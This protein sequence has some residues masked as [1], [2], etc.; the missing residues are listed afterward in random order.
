M[1]QVDHTF[2]L[3]NYLANLTYDDLPPQVIDQAKKSILNSLG[4]GIGYCLHGP[5]EKAFSIIQ[6]DGNGTTATLLGRRQRASIDNAV[7]INGI[8]LTTA[9]YDDTHLK[10]VIHPAGTSLAA[11]L[12]WGEAY[13]MSN[14]DFILAFV[15][16][17]ETQCAVG[18]AISPSHYAQGW[19]VTGTTGSF[20]AAAAISKARKL[21][22]YQFAA[23]LGHSASMASGI[24][25]MFGVDT[26][27]LHMG[28]GAQNGI[29]AARLAAGGFQSC[30]SAIEA[31]AQLV[32]T[33]IHVESISS[34]VET[35]TYEML[36]NTFKP[37]PCG[38][39]IHPLID[40]AVEAHST[41]RWGSVQDQ[42]HSTITVRDIESIEATVNPQC[43][44]LCSVRH[45]KTGLET[46]FSLYH[47]IAVGLL[48]GCAGPDQFSDEGCN[49]PLVNELRDQIKVQTSSDLADDAAILMVKLIGKEEQVFHVEHATGSL[50]RP[51]DIE[52]LERKFIALSSGILG[53]QRATEIMEE[54]WNLERVADMAD[55]VGKLAPS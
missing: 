4:C 10:T 35:G 9:D 12:S 48:Y 14:R 39:V 51:M 3:A 20:G 33:T 18:N 16:G 8:A 27:T 19:H 7:L 50:A 25:A 1:G 45:P 36:E 54:C 17:V 13:H 31:W 43:V 34:L 21:D 23:A 41:L 47:G 46:I 49:D 6:E 15:C 52:Q 5:A 38:I 24:R 11:L 40:A 44:R 53:R 42:S 30:P 22:P 29:L 28:R 32:S 26:K 55:F 37:Y 2:K